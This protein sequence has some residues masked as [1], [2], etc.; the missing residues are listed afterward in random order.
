V[1]V[2]SPEDLYGLPLDR[3]IPE[4]AALVKAL[5]GEKRREEASEIAALRKP[6]VAAWAVNQLVRTQPRALQAL[7][8]AG[9]DLAQAQALA[10]AGKGGGDVMRDATRRQ[11]DA[12]RELLGAAEGL[13]SS[14]GHAL[15]QTMIERVAE[16]LRAAG[17]DEEAQRQVAGGCLTHELRF[18]GVGIG[19][20]VS[21][22]VNTEQRPAGKTEA[23]KAATAPESEAG[24]A[25]AESE[26][27]R[28]RSAAL[29]AARQAEAETRRAATRAHKEMVAAQ[30]R[31]EEAAAA[32]EEAETLLSAAAQRA[33]EADAKLTTADAA[34]RDLAE[35]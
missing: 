22:S 16:T 20:L 25:A 27:A 23:E 17:V 31:R 9:E 21:S 5:R 19:G 4:R 13:L 35:S 33:K 3:F 1:P 15:S 2:D 18:A 26:A 11:R 28:E 6:S 32:L 30:T 24:R 7:F 34:V 12:V 8:G 10:A 29:K 14:E